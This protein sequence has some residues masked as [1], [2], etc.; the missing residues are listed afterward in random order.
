ME[1]SAYRRRKL[2]WHVSK[3]PPDEQNE[4]NECLLTDENLLHPPYNITLVARF[5]RLGIHFLS[6]SDGTGERIRL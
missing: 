3:S 5:K 6:H 2:Q 1:V 4:Q